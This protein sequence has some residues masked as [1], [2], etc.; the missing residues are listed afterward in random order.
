MPVWAWILIAVAAAA[1]IATVVV[2][3]TSA[4]NRA[5]RRYAHHL[6]GKREEARSIKRALE[7]LLGQLR[8]GPDEERARFADDPEA[9]ERHSLSDLAAR[10]RVLAEEL[11]TMPL[12]RRLVPSG[13]ALADAVDV[14]AE[15]AERAGEGSNG[16]ERLEALTMADLER[17][18]RAFA[19]ADARLGP[20]C[21]EY[22]V[23]DES[24]YGRGLYIR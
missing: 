5:V 6:V 12:P 3:L 10:A 23:D 7:E 17:V 19:F 20:L 2:V 22:G 11:N 8:T 18:G 21:Q 14:L 24:M 4:W 15:E 16:D 13:E 9:I 1:I